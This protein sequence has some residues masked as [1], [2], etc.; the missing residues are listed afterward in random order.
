M[1]ALAK[2][3]QHDFWYPV[4]LIQHHESTPAL[5]DRWTVCIWRGCIFLPGS[6]V[7][8]GEWVEIATCDLVDAL[9]DD[10]AT[11][12]LTRVGALSWSY[13]ES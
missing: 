6:S 12:R 1:G 8:G 9:G 7:T 3:P 2:F 4:R 5:K 13:I 11:R 10:S